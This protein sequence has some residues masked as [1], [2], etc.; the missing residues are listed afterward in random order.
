MWSNSCPDSVHDVFVCDS[1]SQWDAKDL[2]VASDFEGLILRSSSSVRVH[3]SHAWRKVD[4]TFERSIWIL[5]LEVMFLSFHTVLSLVSADVAC[6]IL[7]SISFF[8]PLVCHDGPKVFEVG[9]CFKV[10]AFH[11]DIFFE[12]ISF[13]WHDL[14]FFLSWSPCHKLL[15]LFLMFWQGFPFLLSCRPV[16]LYRR[17]NVGLLL[18]CHRFWLC[19]RD[20]QVH[21]SWSSQKQTNKQTTTTN[22]THTIKQNKTNTPP[23]KKTNNQQQQ[24]QPTNQTNKKKKKTKQTKKKKPLLKSVGDGK[25]PCLTLL[26]SGTSLQCFHSRAL[27]LW[28][29][30]CCCRWRKLSLSKILSLEYLSNVITWVWSSSDQQV[31]TIYLIPSK[32]TVGFVR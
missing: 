22:K 31:S 24:N 21:G 10:V 2:P 30:Y 14:C 6:A 3:V 20:S 26:L 32:S 16:H 13:I 23:P 9:H 25:Y 27:R 29:C 28:L 1:V 15:M 12:A 4:V 18:F 17:Q 8:W 7:A 19:I 5:C 11:L